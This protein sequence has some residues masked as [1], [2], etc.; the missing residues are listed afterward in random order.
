MYNGR[1]QILEQ[2]RRCESACDHRC[3]FSADTSAWLAVG[4]LISCTFDVIVLVADQ[5]AN[6]RADG[7]YVCQLVCT[8]FIHS[9]HWLCILTTM[10]LILYLKPRSHD[11]VPGVHERGRSLRSFNDSSHLD[12]W[13]RNFWNLGP[14]TPTRSSRSLITRVNFHLSRDYFAKYFTHILQSVRFFNLQY[15]WVTTYK[16]M[17]R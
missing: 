14:R 10:H 7:L 5:C 13:N 8:T 17:S 15:L 2:R 16:S 11:H 3:I 9:R 6:H 12:P 1:R 4:R